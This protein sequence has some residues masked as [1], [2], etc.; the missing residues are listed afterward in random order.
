MFAVVSL[1]LSETRD[2]HGVVSRASVS[3]DVTLSVFFLT[4]SYFFLPE[5]IGEGER[6]RLFSCC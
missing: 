2:R 3:L 1:V 6:G 4:L 5:A